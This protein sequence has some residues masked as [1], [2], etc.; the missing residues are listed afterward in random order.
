MCLC[1]YMSVY[2]CVCVCVCVCAYVYV[3]VCAIVY[4]WSAP[5]PFPTLNI[6]ATKLLLSTL[7]H[8]ELQKAF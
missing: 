2:V 3:C 4:G 5:N 1:L 8:T 7:H 6:A